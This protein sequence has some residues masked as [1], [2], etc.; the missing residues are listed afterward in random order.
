MAVYEKSVWENATFSISELYIGICKCC[1]PKNLNRYRTPK[2]T[3][4]KKNIPVVLY[5]FPG[6]NALTGS[7]AVI[8]FPAP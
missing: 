1:P 6:C 7:P 8:S 2:K 5:S 3:Y 4:K